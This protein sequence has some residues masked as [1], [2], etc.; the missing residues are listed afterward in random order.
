ME[1]NE[2][3]GFEEERQTQTQRRPRP[4]QMQRRPAQDVAAAHVTK[5]TTESEDAVAKIIL[6]SIPADSQVTNVRFE[7]PNIALYTKNPKFAL[8][9][10]T[11]YLSSLSKTLKKRFIIRTDPSVRLPEDATRQA[12]VK[13][14]PKDV[15]VSAV[16]CD[17]ATGE[18][19]LE[20]S[21]PEAIDPAMIVEIAK[22]TGWIA[23]TRRS[24][25]IPSTSINTIHSTLKSSAKERSDFLQKLGRRLFRGSLVV[26]NVPENGG[27]GR[28]EQASDVVLPPRPQ[29]SQ[30]REEVMLFCLGGVKQV[31]RS[32]FIVVTPES[33][34]MLDCG[35][36]PGEMSG[37][38]AYPRIDWLNFNLDELD[39]VVISHAHI[40]H[41]G[42]LPAL[43]K[44]GYRGPVYCT[45]PTLPLMTLLQMDSVK[46]AN[47]N[48]TYLPYE[49]RDVHE[50]IKHTIT[51]PYGKPTDISPDITVTLNNAGHIMGSA[52]V[53][54][55]ISG[56]H[57][58]LYS[59]DYKFART[60]L[61]DSAVATYPRVETL[62]TESTYGNSSDIMPDQAFVYRTFSESINKVLSEGGKVLIP[63]PAVGR[64]QEIMLV[65]AKEMSEGR[66]VESPIYIEGMISE[67]SAIHMS[68]A[69]YLGADVRRSVSQGINPFTSEYFTVISG[70]KREEA[71]NDQNPAIIM[72]TSGMLE[73]GPSVEYFKELA[74]SPKNK[75]I[76]V[77]YQI[78][79]TLGR[80]VLDG[81]VSEVSMMDKSGKVKV[82]P[83]RCQTQKI[84]GFSGHSDFNQIMN[85]VAKIKP[86]R[87]LVNHGE[88]TKSENV[89]SAIYSRLKIRSGVPDNREIV[90]LR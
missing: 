60:Q 52:T 70:G 43:F 67:A 5:V 2:I 6:Q 54:L 16:F 51:L 37:L 86:K 10:L 20:V 74:P 78:N 44:Y 21:K 48:G 29:W 19:V 50:V 8:T 13:L 87:V 32:C 82:V 90:R 69:H 62:I 89:A 4:E 49:A 24:P 31:G 35:I 47:S 83:V 55:N 7:G 81:N 39:A 65:M 85:F 66:L 17:D 3:E 77:S 42:F 28:S 72:A 36:N 40:D 45:E 63:V 75:I 53:H 46:I 79:G 61:L 71:I 15:Q 1:K 30:N 25:H 73:G 11:Y 84:D 18:V 59:G 41:Q 33:K 22:S 34:V 23:H 27:N 88:R 68:Y 38:D 12:V 14:L 56:A 76:F 57:N 26:G 80:R 64:A 9:E 58:I